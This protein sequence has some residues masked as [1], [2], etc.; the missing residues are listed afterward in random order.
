MNEKQE[1]TQ[2]AVAYAAVIAQTSSTN[3]MAISAALSPAAARKWQA[4]QDLLLLEG[5]QYFLPDFFKAATV[6]SGGVSGD[7]FCFGLY[8]PF[9]D[10]MWL[11]SV[12]GFDKP[13][14]VDFRWV[15][16]ASLRSEQKPLALPTANG[17]NPPSD[18]FIVML[19]SVG[20]AMKGFVKRFGGASFAAE[21]AA[22]P[23]LTAAEAAG[24][25]DVMKLRL[26]Q[27][28]QM[29]R[30]KRGT[31][32][33]LLGAQVLKNGVG[34]LGVVPAARKRRVCADE[35]V[36]AAE[37]KEKLV[38]RSVAQGGKVDSRQ[39][40]AANCAPPICLYRSHP[41]CKQEGFFALFLR[42]TQYLRVVAKR[43]K[44]GRIL[45]KTAA[46][47]NHGTTGQNRASERKNI[48]TRDRAKPRFALGCARSS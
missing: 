15:S 2:Q 41:V 13:Q 12:K 11:A 36:F 37:R 22:L 31:G 43:A 38:R 26:A 30:N 20:D 48:V 25:V 32:T 14:I 19:K 24:M 7:A 33:L 27:I 4:Q 3:C 44:R 45:Q 21:L 23:E 46:A 18:Y 10:R 5:K 8:N 1:K 47:E 9:H 17:V 40:L 35:S 28:V 42:V 29:Q 39:H 16:G 34:K 6:F